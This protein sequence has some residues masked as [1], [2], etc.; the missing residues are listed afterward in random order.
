MA[1]LR[2][3]CRGWVGRS[4]DEFDFS[5]IQA[6]FDNPGTILITQMLAKLQRGYYD[7]LVTEGFSP[8]EAI[9]L[10]DLVTMTIIKTVGEAAPLITQL[11][12]QRSEGD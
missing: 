6:A 7:G 1:C 12:I 10:V 5:R 9:K 8:D 11:I 2:A 3:E 4:V